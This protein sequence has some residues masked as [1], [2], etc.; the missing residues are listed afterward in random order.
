M[1][2]SLHV[3]SIFISYKFINFYTFAH[4]EASV[5][6]LVLPPAPQALV[7]T[8]LNQVFTCLV[9]KKQCFQDPRLAIGGM[10]PCKTF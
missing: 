6:L 10:I 5:E 1:F 3:L 9:R 8:H 7:A 4:A 2:A